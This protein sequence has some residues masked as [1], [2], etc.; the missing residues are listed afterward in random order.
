MAKL[1]AFNPQ[2]SEVRS[3]LI[4][5]L[6]EI[7]SKMS[8]VL[9]VK[10]ATMEDYPLP[11]LYVS[12]DIRYKMYEA[13]LGNKLWLSS[14]APVFKKNGEVITPEK[15]NFT[16]DYLG[17]SI[18]FEQGFELTASDEVTITA[19]YITDGSNKIDEIMSDISEVSEI[20]THYKG[21]YSTVADLLGEYATG[22]DGDFAIIG[23]KNAFYVWNGTDS[24]WVNAFK[25]YNL[26]VVKSYADNAQA[27]ADEAKEQATNAS[28]SADNAKA[29]EDKAKE[30]EDNA[31]A[32]ET[33]SASSAT[34]A[35]EHANNASES[36]QNAKTYSETAKEQADRAVKANKTNHN[37]LLNWDFRNLVNRMG[38]TT[39]DYSSS[40]GYTIDLWRAI[41]STVNVGNGYLT[42]TP[43]QTGELFTQFLVYQTIQQMK[44]KKVTFSF[45]T[46]ENEL[47]YHSET[48]PT[49]CEGKYDTGDNSRVKGIYADLY[50]QTLDTCSF[51]FVITDASKSYNIVACKLEIGDTQTLAEQDENGVWQIIDFADYAEQYTLCSQYKVGTNELVGNVSA[52]S[53]SVTGTLYVN[54][55][56]NVSHIVLTNDLDQSVL[57]NH[58]GNVFEI[59]KRSELWNDNSS[60]ILYLNRVGDVADSSNA[61]LNYY[62]K[63]G[64]NYNSVLLKTNNMDLITNWLST[65]TVPVGGISS[66]GNVMV[67]NSSYPAFCAKYNNTLSLFENANGTFTSI[68]DRVD[69]ST[70]NQTSLNIITDST[71]ITNCLQ[72]NINRNGV[73]SRA[74]IL[75]TMNMYTVRNYLASQALSVISLKCSDV[76]V[77]FEC[78]KYIDFHETGSED[79]SVRLYSYGTIL[80]INSPSIADKQL[81]HY[82]WMSEDASKGLRQSTLVTSDTNPSGNGQ[83]CWTYG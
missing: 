82:G 31:K 25:E 19:S 11:E 76:N 21:F 4:A 41:S 61:L 26:E 2:T 9:D 5:G 62:I 46:A 17:G 12:E 65:I 10:V 70:D 66:S 30:S 20:A 27:S 24:E 47:Y 56:N 35:E 16:V 69:N 74:T 73:N 63:D 53:G 49:E 13:P 51:R 78:S 59:K 29:S 71:N 38:L 75:N 36:E 83:I 22:E 54:A 52:Y 7:A 40:Q 44:G 15:D 32:S 3:P 67:E 57:S 37:L 14:P 8:G 77:P 42:I 1:Q 18:V 28:T 45:L 50:G 79:Y 6:S 39:Y 23:E 60:N 43:S 64:T 34:T 81:L 72:L 80:Y 48:V 33:A 55:E 68:I 58:R